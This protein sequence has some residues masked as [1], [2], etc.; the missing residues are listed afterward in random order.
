MVDSA[1]GDAGASPCEPHS[2]APRWRRRDG[3]GAA[4]GAG[5]GQGGGGAVAQEVLLGAIAS[6]G[7]GDTPPLPITP[8]RGAAWGAAAGTL[9]MGVIRLPISAAG[10]QGGGGG[11]VAQEVLVGR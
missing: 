11:A 8:G 3:P 7:A 4:G 6:G 5:G 1:P 2:G 10:A 9:P